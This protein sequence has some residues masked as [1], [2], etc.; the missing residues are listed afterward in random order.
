MRILF[1]FNLNFHLMNLK[2]LKFNNNI[3]TLNLLF[4]KKFYI[5]TLKSSI[6]LLNFSHISQQEL[7]KKKKV[8]YL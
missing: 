1:F 8:A 7:R 5:K 4:I 2:T 6:N 3:F